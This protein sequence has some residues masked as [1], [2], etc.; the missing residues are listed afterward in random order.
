MSDSEKH[1]KRVGGWVGIELGQ[2]S[3]EEL[4]THL[5]EAWQ[6]IAPKKLKSTIK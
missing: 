5:R 1:L 2:I 3:D 4:A 6:I